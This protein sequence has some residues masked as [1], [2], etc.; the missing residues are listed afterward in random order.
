MSKIPPPLITDGNTP[1]RYTAK[2]PDFTGPIAQNRI[3]HIDTGIFRYG[4]DDKAHAAALV[5]SGLLLASTMVVVLAGIVQLITGHDA[6]W[7]NTVATWIG[8]AFLFTSGIAVGRSG[9]SQV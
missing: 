4:T 6:Q 2:S 5:L 9:S 1:D 3:L 8:N 7:L